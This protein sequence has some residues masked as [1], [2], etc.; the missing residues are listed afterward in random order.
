MRL[1]HIP[2]AREAILEHELVL[3][4]NRALKLAGSWAE[5]FANKQQLAL[6]I[7]MGR[8]RFITTAALQEPEVN[9]LGLEIRPE[10]ILHAITRV[11]QP[12]ANLRF[13]FANAAL[14]EEFFAAGEV[15]RMMINFPDPWPKKRHAKRRLT[16]AH[17][18]EAYWR[19]LAPGGEVHF[20]T[21]D[22]Q[23]FAWSVD[24]L[25]QAG[26][27]LLPA[28]SEQDLELHTEYQRRFLSRGV[29]ICSAR[30]VKD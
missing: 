9:F 11:K 25:L 2:G 19:L 17:Y 26:F 18:A 27:K 5:V 10:M 21:D 24:N 28:A 3:D 22:Q 4:S 16:A 6:E 12:L 14:L 29:Q 7:G 30:L 23:L 1:R 20:K 13:L 8:G 15:Q